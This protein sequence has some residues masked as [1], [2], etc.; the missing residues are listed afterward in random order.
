MPSMG[1]LHSFL[2]KSYCFKR[3][4]NRFD[5]HCFNFPVR[6]YNQKLSVHINLNK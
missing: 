3:Y 1:L 2:R 6:T 5:K 4:Q